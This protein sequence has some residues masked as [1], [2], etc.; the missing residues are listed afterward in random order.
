MEPRM[1]A[2]KHEE[3][4]PQMEQKNT[5]ADKYARAVAFIR[6]SSRVN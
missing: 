1:D 4:K 6:G 5:N 3:I 2:K